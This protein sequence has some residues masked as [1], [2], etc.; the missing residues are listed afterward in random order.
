MTI[1][2]CERFF[3]DYQ[4][5]FKPFYGHRLFLTGATGFF[6]KWMLSA[7]ACANRNFAADIRV[8]AL[9]RNP[10]K[11]FQTYPEFHDLPGID[12]IAGD[13]RQLTTVDGQY[14]D[15]FHA[16]TESCSSLE[17]DDP[18]ELFD[19]IAS[20]TREVLTFARRTGVK[21][22]LYVS[23][24]SIYG[25]QPLTVPRLAESYPCRPATIYGE[26]KQQAEQLCRNSGIPVTIARGF[27]FI[28]PYL[29][30]NIHFAAGNF[31]RD[32]LAGQAP[33]L[34]SDGSSIRSYLY[35]GD[36]VLWLLRIW[37]AGVPGTIY[38][39][40][41][42]QAVTIKELAELTCRAAGIPPRI[43][44][45]PDRRFSQYLPDVSRCRNEL[46]LK[47]FTELSEAL[48]ETL[49]FHRKS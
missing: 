14:D 21:R 36:L 12:F 2:W 29:P 7:L 9:S 1:P 24:G 41:S 32:C 42:D 37:T 30:L 40:G 26:G 34:K 25:P 38:N 27:T 23:S 6:G 49:A 17:H 19:V 45:G 22:M 43:Q 46:G 4:V 15:L 3:L 33:I 11:F 8:T 20:G 44:L 16:A 18:A 28:G 10:E 35:T 39:V 48:K 5:F 47:V 13:V 31:I